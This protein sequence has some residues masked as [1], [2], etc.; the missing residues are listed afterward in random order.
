[1]TKKE[2][3]EQPIHTTYN[4][5]F[6]FPARVCSRRR[7]RC[8]VY[9]LTLI[10]R[11]D[12]SRAVSRRRRCSEKQWETAGLCQSRQI[13]LSDIR[14]D[15]IEIE[16]ELTT[17]YFRNLRTHHVLSDRKYSCLKPRLREDQ[18]SSDT[19]GQLSS[20]LCVCVL[21]DDGP[22]WRSAFVFLVSWLFDD[23]DGV[24]RA[25]CAA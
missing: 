9:D 18:F 3:Q 2:S 6:S 24:G 15:S 1:M 5:F 22:P 21:S 10:K 14:R 12:T 7:P 19:R 17:F 25:R 20:I 11:G 8:R 23:R 16:A 13:G 4:S